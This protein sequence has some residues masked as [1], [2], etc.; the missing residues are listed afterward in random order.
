MR[1][2]IK[3]LRE[4]IQKAVI[5]ASVGVST[6]SAGLTSAMAAAPS[7]VSATQTNKV[8][9][10]VVWIGIIAIGSAGA[11][12]AVIKIVEGQ[13]N[14]DVRGRNSGIAGLAVTAAAVGA[15]AA[16]KTIFFS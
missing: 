7:G 11:I 8:I 5:S 9:D 6:L 10:I 1:R 3:K 14:E 12:P 13:S 16:I 2:K 15:M 4:K